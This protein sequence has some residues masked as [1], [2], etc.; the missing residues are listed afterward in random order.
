[1]IETTNQKGRWYLHSIWGHWCQN[2]TRPRTLAVDCPTRGSFSLV[3]LISCGKTYHIISYHSKT[4]AF[5]GSK[6]KPQRLS[7]RR[8]RRGTMS[9]HGWARL[10]Q[11]QADAGAEG[12]DVLHWI[13]CQS[14]SASQH[15]IAFY[16]L[17]LDDLGI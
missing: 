10:V 3:S 17:D 16:I 5:R 2:R 15:G 14:E 9:E 7:S 6:E 12:R 11:C 13:P 1:M 8:K 4:D